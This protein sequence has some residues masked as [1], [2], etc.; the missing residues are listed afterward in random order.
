M[1]PSFAVDADTIEFL[2][3]PRDFFEELKVRPLVLRLFVI[4]KFCCGA[5]L[6]HV[7]Q[8][9]VLAARKRIALASLHLLSSH[10]FILWHCGMHSHANT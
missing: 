10:S 4:I 8:K 1:G 7:S 9:G 2:R 3:E 5:A 6:A